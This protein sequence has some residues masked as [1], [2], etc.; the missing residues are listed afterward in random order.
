MTK[1]PFS[2]DVFHQKLDLLTTEEP[3]LLMDSVET[4]LRAD[5]KQADADALLRLQADVG[6][7]LRCDDPANATGPLVAPFAAQYKPVTPQRLNAVLRDCADALP[8][9]ELKNS[10]SALVQTLIV[11]LPSA[12]TSRKPG[13][14]P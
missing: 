7:Y 1:E 3:V 2:I 5:G 14:R 4:A 9:G 11:P 13:P 10:F 8:A 12:Q 6:M